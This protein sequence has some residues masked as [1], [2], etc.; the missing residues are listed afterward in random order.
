MLWF[1]VLIIVRFFCVL[2]CERYRGFS[3][4]G[5]LFVI[6]LGLRVEGGIIRKFIFRI[7]TIDELGG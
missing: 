3:N 7:L 2:D 1:N 5:L 4:I 6:N